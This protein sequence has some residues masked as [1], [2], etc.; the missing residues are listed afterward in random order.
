MADHSNMR[1][2][3]KAAVAP[4]HVPTL[5]RYAV[6]APLPRPPAVVDW[7]GGVAWPMLA[8]DTVGDCVIAAMLHA[9]AAAQRWREG[10]AILQPDRIALA[11]YSAIGKYVPGHPAT[12]NGLVIADAM[13]DWRANGIMTEQGLNRAQGVARVEHAPQ[14]KAA[15]WLL[16]PLILGVQLPVA[17]QTQDVWT[18]PANLDGDNAPGSWGGHCVLLVGMDQ[19][20]VASLVTW[21]GV[22]KAE[23][24]WMDSYLDETWIAVQSDWVASGVTPCGVLADRIT[25]DM[26]DF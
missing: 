2:G 14:T 22:K 26:G 1:L 3:K 10:S 4:V 20:G 24:G 15:L 13:E 7:S 17:A 8:N 9:I 23:A 21:G 16:G 19:D 11:N 18:K 12:D 5:G 25:A 6:S